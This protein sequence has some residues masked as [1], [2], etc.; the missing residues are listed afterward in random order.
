M[1]WENYE[2]VP[3][4]EI[5]LEFS[6]KYRIILTVSVVTNAKAWAKKWHKKHP[7][8]LDDLNLARLA[9]DAAAQAAAQN[10]I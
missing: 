5:L 8:Y 2:H 6:G 1:G 4:P 7:N 10:V 9:R 3:V